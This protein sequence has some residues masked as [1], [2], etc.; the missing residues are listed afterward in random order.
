MTNHLPSSLPDGSVKANV[1]FGEE[2][3]EERYRQ[4]I[5]ACALESDIA[6]FPEGDQT[7]VGE[8][9]LSMSGCVVAPLALDWSV[10]DFTPH[11][12]RRGQKA[13][14]ALARAVY[15]SAPIVL[16]DDILSAVDS[17]T[18]AH[19]VEYC[20]NGPL[21]EGRTVILVTHF[22]QMCTSKLTGCELVVKLQK[23][24]I[25]SQGPPGR[26]SGS[27]TPTSQSM[28]KTPSTMSLSGNGEDG[29]KNELNDMMDNKEE[30]DSSGQISL[31]VWREYLSSMGGWIFWLSYAVVNLTAHL[32]MMSQVSSNAFVACGACADLIIS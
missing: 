29:V 18:A 2:E 21:L 27:L 30:V 19:I 3:D 31:Q 14:I 26:S 1:L 11:L 22:V 5:F 25:D 8:K 24:R 17:H 4:T 13:R 32:F 7:R 15:A 16:L 23:G 9:G 28:R 6:G 12:L 10:T 20:L